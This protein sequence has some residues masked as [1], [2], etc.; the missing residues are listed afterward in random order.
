M[1]I[2]SVVRV[3]GAQSILGRLAPGGLPGRELPAD[4]ESEGVAGDRG[5][6]GKGRDHRT[7]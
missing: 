7:E 5:G 4:L 1:P 6:T 2:A 3:T